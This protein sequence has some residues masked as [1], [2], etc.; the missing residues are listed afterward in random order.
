MCGNSLQQQQKIY[1][2]ATS[3]ILQIEKLKQYLLSTVTEERQSWA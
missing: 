1:T 2:E 3:L